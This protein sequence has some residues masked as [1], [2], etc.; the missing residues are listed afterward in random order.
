MENIQQKMNELDHKLA[1]KEIT[2][3]EYYSL[4]HTL[5]IDSPYYDYDDNYMV[6][7]D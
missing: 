3:D 1:R 6:Y 2:L 5:E 7:Q 4:Y